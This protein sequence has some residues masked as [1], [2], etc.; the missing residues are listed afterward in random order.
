M[1]NLCTVLLGAFVMIKGRIIFFLSFLDCF[2]LS[3]STVIEENLF[4]KSSAQRWQGWVRNSGFLLQNIQSV[5][6]LS[7]CGVTM[8][9]ASKASTQAL[10]LSVNFSSS[11][12]LDSCW[13]PGKLCLGDD[14]IGLEKA[15]SCWSKK[16]SKCFLSEDKKLS[17]HRTNQE[18]K[19]KKH[20]W[21]N[22][23][24]ATTTG[25]YHVPWQG[26]LS[27]YS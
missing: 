12:R 11:W 17:K 15:L 21:D 18:E 25:S 4:V 7:V 26:S 3:P 10:N 19:K 27:S 24:L 2:L 22:L 14:A 16:L 5:P 9:C 23:P 1:I 13:T 8:H 20:H 6:W